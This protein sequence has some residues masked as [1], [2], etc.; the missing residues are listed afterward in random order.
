MKTNIRT[1]LNTPIVS[2]LKLPLQN[3]VKT[4]LNAERYVEGSV[5]IAFFHISLFQLVGP[6]RTLWCPL[7]MAKYTSLSVRIYKFL[8]AVGGMAEIRVKAL[9]LSKCLGS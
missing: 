6:D 7:R 8:G 5:I 2:S 1:S 9:K 4:S 3:L